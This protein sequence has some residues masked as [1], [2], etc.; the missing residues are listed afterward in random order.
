M[1]EFA[2]ANAKLVLNTLHKA[3][4]YPMT[5]DLNEFII[6]LVGNQLVLKNVA[7]DGNSSQD[8][9]VNATFEIAVNKSNPHPPPPSPRTREQIENDKA[10]EKLFFALWPIT[11]PG[12]GLFV[13]HEV[14]SIN[15]NELF[16]I[17]KGT[18]TLRHG[19]KTTVIHSV[20]GSP[21]PFRV[22]QESFFHHHGKIVSENEKEAINEALREAVGN[23]MSEYRYLLWQLQTSRAES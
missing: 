12:A 17:V 3:S 23:A 21:R 8:I 6:H 13:L 19:R 4:P 20:G 16:L 15:T 22:K 14:L 7:Q 2:S 1:N 18:I 11:F 5:P 10:M 9:L